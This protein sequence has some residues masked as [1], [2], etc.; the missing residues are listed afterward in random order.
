MTETTPVHRSLFK[1]L[2]KRRART[3]EQVEAV[4]AEFREK[5]PEREITADDFREMFVRA[6]KHLTPEYAAI[7]CDI[8]IKE[9]PNDSALH[10]ERGYMQMKADNL[11]EAAHS[12]DRALELNEHNAFALIT[13]ARLAGTREK[14]YDYA[15][16][17]YLKASKLLAPP[18]ANDDQKHHYADALAGLAQCNLGMEKYDEAIAYGEEF[19]SVRPAEGYFGRARLALAY[20]KRGRPED[21]F[22]VMDP[23]ASASWQPREV[24]GALGI[25]RRIV[26]AE[27]CPQEMDEL[28][29]Q[30]RMGRYMQNLRRAGNMSGERQQPLIDM[31]DFQRLT[32][33]PDQW[34]ALPKNEKQAEHAQTTVRGLSLNKLM[35]DAALEKPEGRPPRGKG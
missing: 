35:I 7:L 21:A 31:G 22:E 26:S 16:P 3:L 18:F 5:Y 9:F 25:Q 29:A 19:L 23:I 11:I 15:E 32:F 12:L 13:R 1:M 24:R 34:E 20:I 2:D 28:S 17:L 10:A 27:I 30:S 14:W 33:G 4:I 6:I 8:G